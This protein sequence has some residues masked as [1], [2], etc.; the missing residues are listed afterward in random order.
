MIVPYVL[1][2]ACISGGAP[3][4]ALRVPETGNRTKTALNDGWR[5]RSRETQLAIPTC[6]CFRRFLGAG[7]RIGR[8]RWTF[9]RPRT[10][11][12]GIAGDDAH[13]RAHA[14][15]NA[16]ALA[17]RIANDFAFAVAY[18]ERVADSVG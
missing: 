7:A 15:I 11:N 6:N 10:N 3:S 13:H 9:E 8:R 16:D 17:H 4:A 2:V 5:H 1:N 18:G 14:T 12:S